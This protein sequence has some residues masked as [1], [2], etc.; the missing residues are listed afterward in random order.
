MP[1]IQNIQLSL[2]ISDFDASSEVT[3]QYFAMQK[4]TSP[5]QEHDRTVNLIILQSIVIY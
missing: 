5:S 3:L 1:Q 2:D 4:N